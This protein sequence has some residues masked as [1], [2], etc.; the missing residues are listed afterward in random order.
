MPTLDEILEG[1]ETYDTVTAL[2]Q[3]YA[4]K[5]KQRSSTVLDLRQQLT[6]FETDFKKRAI[7]YRQTTGKSYVISDMEKQQYKSLKSRIA[8]H[9]KSLRDLMMSRKNLQTVN[10][11]LINSMQLQMLC[12]AHQEITAFKI[13]AKE[14]EEISIK[15]LK[16]YNNDPH[17]LVQAVADK[18]QPEQHQKAAQIAYDTYIKVCKALKKAKQ[19]D[20]I[21][22]ITK[23]HQG[24]NIATNLYITQRQVDQKNSFFTNHT[25]GIERATQFAN[26]AASLNKP[27]VVEKIINHLRHGDGSMNLKSFKTQIM[28]VMNEWLYLG[29]DRE[30]LEKH[31]NEMV[32]TFCSTLEQRYGNSYSATTSTENDLVG[33][34][35]LN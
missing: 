30:Q 29:L 28:V 34:W 20:S 9:E 26:E 6:T 12:P 33:S 18:D 17:Q 11:A 14:L 15:L 3:D 35:V 27:A 10:E 5:I 24:L 21:G 23:V 22:D 25:P 13:R 4:T 2:L 32:E 19:A 31:P 1:R 7:E 8:L 16:H